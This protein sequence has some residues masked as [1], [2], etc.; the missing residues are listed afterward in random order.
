MGATVTRASFAVPD[1]TPDAAE[2]RLAR[3][4]ADYPTI[5]QSR[6]LLDDDWDGTFRKGLGCLLEGLTQRKPS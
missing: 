6:L 1:A 5:G 3:V 4:G 2:Q